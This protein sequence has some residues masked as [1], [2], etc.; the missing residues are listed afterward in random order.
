MHH[1][2]CLGKVL[3]RNMTGETEDSSWVNLLSDGVHVLTPIT[4]PSSVSRKRGMVTVSD[5]TP[6]ISTVSV[7]D[8]HACSNNY[9]HFT[10]F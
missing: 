7:C 1:L 9:V 10:D 4:K 5:C 6:L 8:T 2:E 3:K